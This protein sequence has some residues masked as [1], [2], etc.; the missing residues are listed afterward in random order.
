MLLNSILWL[1]LPDLQCTTSRVRCTGYATVKSLR[2]K[3]TNGGKRYHTL[4]PEPSRMTSPG[5]EWLNVEGAKESGARSKRQTRPT[6]TALQSAVELKRRQILRSRKR[7]LSV[8]QSVEGLS[9]DSH[10]DTVARG[11]TLAS[12][13]FGR[14]LQEC[15]DYLE[16][17]QLSEENETLNRALLLLDSLKNRITRQSNKLLET[18]SVCSRRSSRHS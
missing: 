6:Q 11:L 3:S 7:L 1:T 10:I 18:R 16:E 13:E 5:K 14:L 4:N 9:D 12:E 15:G 8:M 17:A 2:I